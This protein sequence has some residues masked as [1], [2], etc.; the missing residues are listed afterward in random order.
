MKYDH[1]IKIIFFDIDGTMIAMGSKKMTQTMIDT[2]VRLRENGIKICIS[3]SR[4]PVFLPVFEGIEF[5]AFITLNG[6]YCYSKEAVILSN[7]L[8]K[9]E[10]KRIVKNAASI[11]RPVCLAAADRH[12][13]NGEDKDL[14]DYLAIANVGL[15]ISD[16]FSKV[17]DGPIYQIILGCRDGYEETLLKG[18][19]HARLS[20]W[21]ER[22]GDIVPKDAAKSAGVS[23]ILTHYGFCAEEAM[24]FGDSANDIDMLKA[25]GLG[26]A[27]GNASD[28]VKALADDV[29]RPVTDEGIYHYCKEMGLI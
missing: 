27:M 24:A 29:C 1:Q 7:P 6:S 10:V 25:V 22:A 9:E 12:V 19:E 3:T 23:R 11:R 14:E 20:F 18:T 15:N 26:V 17:L 8:P 2:L 16:D 4:A 28:E 21:W 13:S 5:D